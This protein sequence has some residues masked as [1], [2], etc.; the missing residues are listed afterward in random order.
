MSAVIT[1][2]F[3]VY[4]GGGVPEGTE[5]QGNFLIGV[6]EQDYSINPGGVTWY[7]GP[8]EVPGYI[9]AATNGDA[10]MFWRSQA[11]TNNDFLSM[12]NNIYGELGSLSQFETAEDAKTWLTSNGFYYT[13]N[14]GLCCS[15]VFPGTAYASP[16]WNYLIMD[17]D[18][19]TSTLIDSG[20]PTSGWNIYDVYPQNNLGYMMMFRSIDNTQMNVNW[21]DGHGNILNN[22]TA[23]TN[24]FDYDTLDGVWLLFNDRFNGILTY[25]NGSTTYTYEYNPA[26]TNIGWEWSWDAVTANGSFVL[27]VA[28]QTGSNIQTEYLV[29]QDG[30]LNSIASFDFTTTSLT[31]YLYQAGNN[32]VLLTTDI[33]ADAISNIDILTQA[34]D[35]LESIA[36]DTG[37]GY[38]NNHFSFYDYNKANLILWTNNVT[39]DYLIYNYDGNTNN[40]IATSHARGDNYSSLSTFSNNPYGYSRMGTSNLF[41]VFFQDSGQYDSSSRLKVAYCDIVSA[42]DG[43]DSL[44]TYTF[45]NSGS[46]DKSIDVG[47]TTSTDSLF[48]D[49]NIGDIYYT[50][51]CITP[52]GDAVLTRVDVDTNITDKWWGVFG[53]KYY[54]IAWTGGDYY[55]GTVYIINSLG[56]VDASLPFSNADRYAIEYNSSDSVF[57]FGDESRNTWIINNEM[58]TFQAVGAYTDADSSNSYWDYNQ[59]LDGTTVLFNSPDL[60]CRIINK[61][62]KSPEFTLGAFD[63]TYGF[64]IGRD[65]FLY[66]RDVSGSMT[67]EL[68]D[69]AGT[70]LSTQITSMNINQYGVFNNRAFVTTNDGGTIQTFMITPDGCIEIDMLTYTWWVPNDII[71][72]DY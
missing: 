14:P 66:N 35:S 39:D 19:G 64:Y 9:L 51:L 40:Y 52:A 30:S 59:R 46:L 17:Y 65:T 34:G 22:Y 3:A 7:M 72:W 16:N 68:Y 45:Q 10:P 4:L 50:S 29:P 53:D 21:I 44:T 13:E 36:L 67:W 61:N 47:R 23:T 38:I 62:Y 57:V 71:I 24:S 12:V 6:T 56:I 60:K 33:G 63:T 58:P 31:V 69:F 49:C 8:D 1:R 18:L 25:G 15:V 20:I 41:M 27:Y 43:V 55:A 28:D 26:N 32:I 5:L 37:L 54:L 70:L 48:T 42:I 11:K 2:P